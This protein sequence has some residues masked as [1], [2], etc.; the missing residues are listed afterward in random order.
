MSPAAPATATAT[1]LRRPPWVDH[2]TIFDAPSGPCYMCGRTSTFPSPFRDN[3]F[4]CE[5]LCG[6]PVPLDAH[7]R[8]RRLR[9]DEERRDI[10][11]L[12]GYEFV[13]EYGNEY[14]YDGDD[15][16]EVHDSNN[17]QME[18]DATE[19]E[20]NHDQI[21]IEQQPAS[22]NDQDP[23]EDTLD[24]APPKYEMRGDTPGDPDYVDIYEEMNKTMFPE[25]IPGYSPQPAES[26][27][28]TN[29]ETNKRMSLKG[30][31]EWS[32]QP[33]ES[34]RDMN[35]KGTSKDSGM[36]VTSSNKRKHKNSHKGEGDQEEK[37]AKRQKPTDGTSTTATRK[38]HDS[39]NVRHHQTL[40][41]QQQNPSF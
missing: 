32:L 20:K 11:E 5:F 10:A 24:Y 37:P 30:I 15:E 21:M 13:V 19:Y 26:R 2:W 25:G 41:G 38:A 27:G 14:G 1:R 9:E 39:S 17:D 23:S 31:H 40:S 8:L 22:S 28:N 36:Q 34:R 35:F 4:E 29:E 7:E 18:I 6:T 3:H 33:A 16:D 12:Y